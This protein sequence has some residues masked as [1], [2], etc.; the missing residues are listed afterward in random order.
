MVR[1]EE[2][3][4]YLDT[5]VAVALGHGELGSLGK[6]ARRM[7]DRDRDLRISPMAVLELEFLHEIK[8][9]RI[10]RQVAIETLARE[11]GSRIWLASL[12]PPI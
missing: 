9:I 3:V 12:R 5:H 2:E 1:V 8:R 7:L 6:E 11:F 4:I 10:S